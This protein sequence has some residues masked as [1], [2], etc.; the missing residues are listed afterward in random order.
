VPLTTNPSQQLC[1]HQWS[2]RRSV[3]ERFERS[4]ALGFVELPKFMSHRELQ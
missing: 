3:E 4:L 2:K 1:F